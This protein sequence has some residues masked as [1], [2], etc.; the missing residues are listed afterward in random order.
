MLL[1][2]QRQRLTPKSE[3]RRRPK[4]KREIGHRL[5]KGPRLRMRSNKRRRR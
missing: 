1:R 4:K 5:R 2:G 3:L